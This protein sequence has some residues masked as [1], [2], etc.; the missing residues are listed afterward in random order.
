MRKLIHIFLLALLALPLLQGCASRIPPDGGPKDT[1]PPEVLSSE[2]A[3]GRTLFLEKKITVNFDE[4]IT[5][6]D[7]G[8]SFLVSPPM[9]KAPEVILQG[10]SVVLKFEEEFDA[11][12]TYSITLGESVKDLTESNALK[13]W[14]LVFSTGPILDSLSCQGKVINAYTLEPQSETLVMLYESDVDSLP[15]TSLP[16]YFART[17]SSGEYK[18]ENLK[19]GTYTVFALKD[20]NSNY[21]Y[22]Q[23]GEL[24][25]FTGNPVQIDSMGTPIENLFLSAELP[26]TQRL[27]KKSYSY[28]GV[29][30]LKYALAVDKLELI[31]LKTEEAI[32]FSMH[33]RSTS[34]SLNLFIDSPKSDSLHLLIKSFFQD[35]L[36]L[37]TFEFSTIY[38]AQT[39]NRKQT[40]K[41][42]TLLSFSSNIL[43]AKLKPSQDL[44]LNPSFPAKIADPGL[45]SWFID[46]DTLGAKAEASNDTNSFIFNF[47]PPVLSE[48]VIKL[49]ALPGAF[50]D[51]YGH[52]SDSLLFDFRRMTEDETG[53]IEIVFD[54]SSEFKDQ[55]W[56][57][58]L[59]DSK[60]KI[61]EKRQ[62]KLTENQSFRELI[63]GTYSL[64]L[65]LDSTTNGFWNP[66]N[67]TRR[68]Q[69]EKI[70][71][72]GEDIPVRSGWDL[73][74]DWK[75]I[76]NT[77]IKK[78][79]N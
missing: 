2:P 20:A 66:A 21:I 63:P 31:N 79:G 36:K 71:Y 28:P 68:T 42:D 40:V 33:P 39:G 72:Y 23:P 69:A 22:D 12:T 67:Y 5:L 76:L 25:G 41:A 9:K 56:V 78:A 52:S 26:K 49:R 38:K 18:I 54:D 45:L 30:L 46:G 8:T 60:K 48:K 6:K 44:E 43:Q 24:I 55:L 15:L 53:L 62:I 77:S 27:L 3:T 32:G 74:I 65:I 61:V 57:L 59:L 14:T 13:P 17:N 37:D 35:T 75:V 10:K 70:L 16:R 47:K 19:A 11:Q 58:E 1:T 29:L 4:F 50:K 34:D 73:E 7:G 51:I 64:R